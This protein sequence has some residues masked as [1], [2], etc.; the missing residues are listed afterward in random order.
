MYLHHIFLQQI[1]SVKNRHNWGGVGVCVCVFGKE[2]KPSTE[3]KHQLWR[4]SMRDQHFTNKTIL[5][6][7]WGNKTCNYSNFKM[8][9]F[10]QPSALIKMPTKLNLSSNISSSLY[11]KLS[12]CHICLL[13]MLCFLLASSL[14]KVST[15]FKQEK[16]CT[17][18]LKFQIKHV[19]IALSRKDDNSWNST[20]YDRLKKSVTV[21]LALRQTICLEQNPFVFIH[22]SLPFYPVPHDTSFCKNHAWGIVSECFFDAFTPVAQAKMC[23]LKEPLCSAKQFKGIF[24]LPI[25]QMCIEIMNGA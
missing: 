6:L 21:S 23:I 8:W 17:L 15:I 12:F 25:L 11:S 2:V 1:K 19:C 14:V 4:M 7:H 5:R 24:T 22:K 13:Q 20:I 9:L 3:L 10:Y 16:E 18:K